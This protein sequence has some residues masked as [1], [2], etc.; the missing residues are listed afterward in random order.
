MAQMEWSW[1]GERAGALSPLSQKIAKKNGQKEQWDKK[2]TRQICEIM[3]NICVQ[4]NREKLS[5]KLE[6]MNRTFEDTNK[7]VTQPLKLIPSC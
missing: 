3:E 2:D 1:S 5:T 4:K 6:K 7:T